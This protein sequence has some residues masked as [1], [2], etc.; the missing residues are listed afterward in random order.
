MSEF[1]VWVLLISLAK[2]DNLVEVS[3]WGGKKACEVAAEQVVSDATI[4]VFT[5]CAPR[6]I[7]GARK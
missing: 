4:R 2:G 6:P 3:V 5:V 1:I 7:E